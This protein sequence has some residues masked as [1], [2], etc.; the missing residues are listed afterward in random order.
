MEAR[1]SVTWIQDSGVTTIVD[2][3]PGYGA[4]SIASLCSKIHYRG[5]CHHEVH[6]NWLFDHLQRVF[7]GIVIDKDVKLADESLV[8]KVSTYLRRAAEVAKQLLPKEPNYK[9]PASTRAS[10]DDDRCDDE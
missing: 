5:L 10:P 1:N 7:V 6:K 9:Y 8:A 3:T 2:M 4:A